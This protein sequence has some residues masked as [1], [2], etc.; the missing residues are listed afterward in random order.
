MSA[1]TVTR[2]AGTEPAGQPWLTLM[3]CGIRGETSPVRC[4]NTCSGSAM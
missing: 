4:A 2:R 1:E 3:S